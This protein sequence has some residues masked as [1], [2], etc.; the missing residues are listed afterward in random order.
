MFVELNESM[1]DVFQDDSKITLKGQRNMFF[2]AKDDSHQLT[3]NLYY[4]PNTKSNILNL[5]Q[6]LEKGY[7]IDLKYYSLFLKDDKGNLI[8]KMKVSKNRMFSFNIQNKVA[9]YLKICYKDA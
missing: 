3:L 6:L 2:H 1:K 9:K 5:G 8:T 4:V 7:D